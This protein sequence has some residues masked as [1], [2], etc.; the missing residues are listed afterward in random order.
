[1]HESSPAQPAPTI[2]AFLRPSSPPWEAAGPPTGPGPSAVS[3]AEFSIHANH[4]QM[5][6]V[7]NT[8]A[9]HENCIRTVHQHACMRCHAH[10]PFA[11]MSAR[12]SEQSA[13]HYAKPEHRKAPRRIRSGAQDRRAAPDLHEGAAAPRP[14]VPPLRWRL[15]PANDAS[16]RRRL[17]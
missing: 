7:R 3:S 15:W 6:Q 17:S 8:V 1:M 4:V 14:F 12:Q 5:L 16:R 10:V 11:S 9:S 2:T 13:K